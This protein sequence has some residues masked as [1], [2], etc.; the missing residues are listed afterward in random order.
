MEM[1][2]LDGM[3]GA[4]EEESTFDLEARNKPPNKLE[5]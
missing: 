5:A 3:I 2:I 1:S 4:E